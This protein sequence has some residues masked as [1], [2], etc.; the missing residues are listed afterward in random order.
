MK[1]YKPPSE[2][3]SRLLGGGLAVWLFAASCSSD[4]K[5]SG[6][7]LQTL[8]G[9]KPQILCMFSDLLIQLF[10]NLFSRL[11]CQPQPVLQCYSVWWQL[12]LRVRIYSL[13]LGSEPSA[14]TMMKFRVNVMR[15]WELTHQA[16]Y[17]NTLAACHTA[18]MDR[19]SKKML[20]L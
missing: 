5:T 2:S 16:S 6:P 10:A 18:L 13:V 9:P 12:K 8:R 14:N 20:R 11:H 4:Y 15:G 19:C 3:G 17:S 7:R 1:F